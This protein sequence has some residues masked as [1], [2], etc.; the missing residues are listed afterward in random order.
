MHERSDRDKYIDINF[1]N[2]DPD[3]ISQFD[4]LESVAGSNNVTW[5]YNSVML[6]GSTDF[7]STELKKRKCK[8]PECYTIT[9]KG[10]GFIDTVYRKKPTKQD[11]QN[12]NALYS[13]PQQK[14]PRPPSTEALNSAPAAGDGGIG[15]KAKKN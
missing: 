8:E 12:I 13:C 5:D 14:A 10:G 11:I 9:K 15:G 1:D 7:Q 2:V 3:M 4:I 6:Y